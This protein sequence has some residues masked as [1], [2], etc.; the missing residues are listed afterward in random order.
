MIHLFTLLT[1]LF[2]NKL[3]MFSVT[4][5]NN[6][7]NITVTKGNKTNVVVHIEAII[8]INI[9]YT[10]KQTIHS[11]LLH[12]TPQNNCQPILGN[13][14]P[15]KATRSPEISH[16]QIQ[17]LTQPPFSTRRLVSISLLSPPPPPRGKIIT[18]LQSFEKTQQCV[19]ELQCKNF[20]KKY[21][22][23]LTKKFTKNLNNIT[24][25]SKTIHFDFDLL[26]VLRPLFCALTLG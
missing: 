3:T 7:P 5:D 16:Q 2:H 8:N 9:R 17:K 18:Y 25:I 23:F 20:S 22:I 15:N 1:S 13:T 6:S 26:N 21:I 14:S 24:S 10:Y 19:F 12:I 11:Y 4:N